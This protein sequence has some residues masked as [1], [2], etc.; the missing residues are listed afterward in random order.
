[1]KSFNLI[2]TKIIY[3]RFLVITIVSTAIASAQQHTGA[4]KWEDQCATCKCLWSSG[5][6]TAYCETLQLKHIPTTLHPSLQTLELSNNYISEIQRDEFQ[7]AGIENI[8]RLVMKNCSLEAINEYAFTGLGVLIELDLSD[9]AI[10]VLK[11]RT[12][13]AIGKVRSIILNNNRVEVLP[14]LLFNNLSSL[15]KIEL[16]NNR[17]HT[18]GSYTFNR[19]SS[20]SE[21]N[22][23]SNRLSTLSSQSFK[24]LFKLSSLSISNNPLNCTCDLR[25]FRDFLIEERTLYTPPTTQCFEPVHLKGKPFKDVPKDDF[26]CKP[27]IIHS[28]E[29]FPVRMEVDVN[30]TLFCEIKAWPK[31]TVTWTFNSRP[32]PANNPNSRITTSLNKVKNTFSDTFRSEVFIHKL[33]VDDKGTYKCLASN[34]GGQTS[35][36]IVLGISGIVPIAG[37]STPGTYIKQETNIIMIACIVSGILLIVLIIIT[38]I[39]CCYCRYTRKYIKNGSISENGLVSSKVNKSQNDSMFEGSVIKEMQ[40]ALLTDVNMSN[41]NPVEKPPRRSSESNHSKNS[42]LCDA[43]DLKRT[44]LDETGFG[45][46]ENNIIVILFNINLKVRKNTNKP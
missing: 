3:I 46:F 19:L 11:A 12:F 33:G 1:M 30:M 40:K 39:L 38:I 15:S 23:G 22:L 43:V 25:D 4:D 35:R 36:E 5:K 6:R 8:H 18:I 29:S 45:K 20:L 28:T 2:P 42:D 37:S 26:A 41:V 7:M 21:I 10:T 13:E 34:K 9:N 27:T 24:E 31:P 44:L 16:L 17:I 14:D 32:I